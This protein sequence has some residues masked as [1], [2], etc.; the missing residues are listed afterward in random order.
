[1][2]D[3]SQAEP[4][5]LRERETLWGGLFRG[6]LGQP[7]RIYDHLPSSMDTLTSMAEEGAPEGTMVVSDWQRKGRGRKGRVWYSA[8]GSSLLCALLLRP[9]W[10]P[11]LAGILS[12]GVGLALVR[13]GRVFGCELEVK[14]PNDVLWRGRKLAGVLMEARL[15]A[16]G[17]RHL[18]LG[19]GINV[20]Q[21]RGDFPGEI[22]DIATSLDL[23]TGGKRVARGEILAIWLLEVER[24]LSALNSGR[25]GEVIA[26]WR[27]VWP[28]RGL[29]AIAEDGRTLT[30]LDIGDHGEMLV[31]GPA[32]LESLQAGDLSLDPR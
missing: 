21:G 16:S 20:H 23:A 12:L 15:T 27:E 30:L 25:G 8:P 10:H 18:V 26:S 3:E 13:A 2:K 31:D 24:I 32:G 7:L 29:R 1:M 14:W 28:H 19:V 9:E 6:R 4:V 17:Y 11:H 5:R 22:R